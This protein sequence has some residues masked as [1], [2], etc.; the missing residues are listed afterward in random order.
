MVPFGEALPSIRERV[1][2]DL[3]SRGID[4]AKVLAAIVRI[5]DQTGVRVGN[6]RYRKQNGSYGLTTLRCKHVDINGSVVDLH[7]RGKSGRAQNVVLRDRALVRIIRQCHEL[8][9]YE[10][11]QYLDD[12]EQRRGVDSADV[13]QYLEEIA[14]DRFTAKEFRTWAGSRLALAGILERLDD[15]ETPRD[16][17]IL[18]IVDA[19]AERLGNQRDTCREFY[20]HPAL[21]EGFEQGDLDAALAA[22]KPE[23]VPELS[24]E[25]RLL[26]AW[27]RS[28][29]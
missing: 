15:D 29:G 4:R 16:E 25:E 7:F 5:L 20:I 23:E 21:L 22:L 8:P 13:N 9:G 12:E 18:E 3:R 28:L 24:S 14:G 10:L 2:S 11:F 17:A 27:L 1:R 19:V 6:E 26:L